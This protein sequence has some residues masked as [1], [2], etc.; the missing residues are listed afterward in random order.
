[1]KK[2]LAVDII[3]R[4]FFS[5]LTQSKYSTKSQR[6]DS[7]QPPA[8]LHTLAAPS[9]VM[10]AIRTWCPRGPCSSLVYTARSSQGHAGSVKHVNAHHH[11]TALWMPVGILAPVS[12]SFPPGGELAVLTRDACQPGFLSCFRKPAPT[13]LSILALWSVCPSW[14]WY[15][16]IFIIS[17][18]IERSLSPFYA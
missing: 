14:G 13:C 3:S 18:H 2:E 16:T 15:R 1:M 9:P 4:S 12:L 5:K 6:C 7:P 11:H 17:L 8:Y 10:G